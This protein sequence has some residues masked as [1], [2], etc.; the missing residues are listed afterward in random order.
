MFMDSVD[1]LLAIQCRFVGIDGIELSQSLVEVI[2]IL[3]RTRSAVLKLR[4]NFTVQ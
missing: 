1:W 3:Q 4:I 2:S